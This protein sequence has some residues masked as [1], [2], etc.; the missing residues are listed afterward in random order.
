MTQR[1]YVRNPKHRRQSPQENRDDGREEEAS[2]QE[3]EGGQAQEGN[4]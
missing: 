4:G 3:G 2:G 1:E